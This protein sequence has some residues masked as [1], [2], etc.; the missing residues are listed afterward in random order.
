MGAITFAKQPLDGD[1]L[2]RLP[3]VKRRDMLEFI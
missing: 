1:A 3:K 2:I